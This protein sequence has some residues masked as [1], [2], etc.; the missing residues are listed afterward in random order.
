VNPYRGLLGGFKLMAA[1]SP[2][3]SQQK[4]EMGGAAS[5]ML[6]AQAKVGQPARHP[7]TAGESLYH[8]LNMPWH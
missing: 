6:A 5:V 3:P 2:H 4:I 7:P 1:S 8:F